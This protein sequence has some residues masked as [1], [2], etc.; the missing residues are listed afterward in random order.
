M[1]F[2]FP[3]ILIVLA[4]GIFVGFINPM[5]TEIQELEIQANAYDVALGDSKKLQLRRDEL[6]SEF[7]NF[8]QNDK[9]RISQMVPDE[10]NNVLLIEEIQKVANDQGISI[11]KVDFD[12]EQIHLKDTEEEE[13]SLATAGLKVVDNSLSETFFM[14]FEV[15][16]SYA[17][18][19]SLLE[20]LETSLRIIDIYG[21][22]FSSSRPIG[23]DESSDV[24]G[25]RFIVKTYRLKN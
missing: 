16:G 24:Y 20:L 5:Y 2:L 10:I 12:P 9:D 23:E 1:R 13:G 17:D 19:V 25:Y 7:N 3:A 6:A 11:T 22:E 21:I 14:E 4:I 18:F 8:D 15:Q